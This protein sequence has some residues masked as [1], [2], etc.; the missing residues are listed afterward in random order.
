[1]SA[2]SEYT[3]RPAP[4]SARELE[5]ARLRAERE[6]ELVA[7]QKRVVAEKVQRIQAAQALHTREFAHWCQ[8][9]VGADPDEMGTTERALAFSQ[10]SAAIASGLTA[11]AHTVVSEL[12]GQYSAAIQP[13]VSKAKAVAAAIKAAVRLIFDPLRSLLQ[14]ARVLG[15]PLEL[16]GALRTKYQQVAAF[17]R[18]ARD[19]A[20]PTSQ[21]AA[22]S[23]YEADGK[24]VMHASRSDGEAVILEFPRV[25]QEAEAKQLIHRLENVFSSVTADANPLAVIDGAHPKLNYKEAFPQ[26]IVLRTVRQETAGLEQK[27]KDLFGQPALTPTNT[28]ILNAAPANI[29][30][31]TAVFQ[32]AQY[33]PLW[34]GIQAKWQATATKHGFTPSGATR[35]DFLG[36]LT[37]DK[38]VIVL[39]AHGNSEKLWFPGP[40]PE[41]SFVTT[42][43]I[44]EFAA[45]IR[46][47][48][49]TVYMYCCEAAAV[50]GL[51][52]WATVLL[53]AG[54]Q[55]VVAP[56]GKV[57]ARRSRKLFDHFLEYGRQEMP[58]T[59]QHRAET[60]TKQRYL[61]TW[62][63]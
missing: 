19:L 28:R 61:E 16:P 11:E 12:E 44:G 3:Y 13:S 27:V 4:D 8:K 41:G 39:V 58:L 32:T 49:P 18:R 14:S 34:M 59:A 63:G 24:T 23:V 2:A 29:A 31:V 48:R 30:E 6:A 15:S 38:N 55:A 40:P 26:K 57:D 25:V 56:Q 45:R 53:D 1:V 62:V 42:A 46:D 43:D 21:K 20:P 47:N 37:E 50:E 7:E 54:V 36:A 35:S 10:Y 9:E 51:E 17:L 5:Q 22:F 60:K 52:N 33:A